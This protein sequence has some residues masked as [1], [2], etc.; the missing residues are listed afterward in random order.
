V[1][2][3]PELIVADIRTFEPVGGNWLPL[4][5]LLAE[6]WDSGAAG[7]HAADLLSVFERF[8][9]EDGDVLWGILH[10]L[11]ALPDYEPILVRSVRALPSEM[12]VMMVGRLLNGGV[13]QVGGVPLVGLLR[14]VAASA[15][16]PK[17]VRASAADWAQMHAAPGTSSPDDRTPP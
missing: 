16:A 12:G 17:K 4:D 13:S 5:A 1:G 9:D 6:L 10:G 11:E 8:S 7:A 3:A 2:R 14:E 15:A